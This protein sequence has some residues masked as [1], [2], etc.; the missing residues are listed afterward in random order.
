MQSKESAC[1]VSGAIYHLTVRANGGAELFDDDDRRYLLGR[2]AAAASTAKSAT[3]TLGNTTESSAKGYF[4]PS[5]GYR[6]LDSWVIIVQF[7]NLRFLRE[8]YHT[9]D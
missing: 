8:V 2:I 3:Q 6:R 5:G 9:R 7:S 1:G 4:D